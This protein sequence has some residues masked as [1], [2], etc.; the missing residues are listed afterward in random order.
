MSQVHPGVC[1]S[2]PAASR[3]YQSDEFMVLPC[4]QSDLTRFLNVNSLL[5]PRLR[6]CLNHLMQKV[7]VRKRASR[8]TARP[9]VLPVSSRQAAFMTNAARESIH[10]KWPGIGCDRTEEWFSESVRFTSEGLP[11]CCTAPSI[12]TMVF[13]IRAS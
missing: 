9:P 7:D 1:E 8:N 10:C 6:Q 2:V 12:C 4:Y 11:S 3:I 5:V 13:R